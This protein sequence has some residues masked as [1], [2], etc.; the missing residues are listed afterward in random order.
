M[1]SRG[2]EVRQAQ[3]VQ[4][5]AVSAFEQT[6]KA[7]AVFSTR[8][9]GVSE[10]HF[11]SLNLGLHRGDDPERVRENFRLFCEAAGLDAGRLVLTAQSHT[12]NV[13]AVTAD[14]CGRGLSRE[15]F[16]DVDGLVTGE[17]NVFLTAFFADCVPAFLLDPGKGVCGVVHSGWRGTAARIAENAVLLMTREYGC[18]PDDIL[19]AVGPSVCARHYEVSEKVA[20]IITKG[21]RCPEAALYTE[22]HWHADLWEA[23]RAVLLQSGIAPAN[24]TM[25][26]ECTVCRPDRYYSHRL[27]GVRRGSLCAVIGLV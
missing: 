24:I 6:G 1:E 8:I 9:G 19:A 22:G 12:K 5:L 17:K 16:S 25:S 15:G 7:K 18:R 26:G 3:G 4:Y 14:D 23:N 20:N 27:C 13:I 11:E 10:G 2:F 21:S